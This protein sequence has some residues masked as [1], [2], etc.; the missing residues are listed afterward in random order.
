MASFAVIRDRFF[1]WLPLPLSRRKAQKLSGCAPENGCVER[2]YEEDIP[3]AAHH[4]AQSNRGDRHSGQIRMGNAASEDT[5]GFPSCE[6]RAFMRCCVNA[7]RAAT[8]NNCAALASPYPKLWAT[9]FLPAS[10]YV[11]P[12]WKR[13]GIPKNLEAFPVHI[14]QLA[15]CEFAGAK[16]DSPGLLAS[17]YAAPT[18]GKGRSAPTHLVT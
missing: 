6:K 4:F 1:L 17:K 10:P 13:T 3:K 16:R 15:G 5:N 7:Q 11:S 8:D 2:A 12:Q 18:S 14:K 9:R